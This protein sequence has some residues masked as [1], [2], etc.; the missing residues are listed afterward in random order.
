MRAM[1]GEVVSGERYI[2]KTAGNEERMIIDSASPL[3][4][5]DGNISGSV[6]VWTDITER[7]KLMIE[8]ERERDKL[9]T[10]IESISDEV[11][12]CDVEG[13]LVLAN[14]AVAQNLG[15]ERVEDLFGQVR[16]VPSKIEVYDAQ[17]QPLSENEAPLLRSLRGETLI[18]LEEF[19]RNVKTGELRF[20]RDFGS[21][22]RCTGYY[23]TQ[24]GP[25]C[26]T[27]RPR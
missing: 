7:E 16:E 3:Y 24:A 21:G 25:G 13:N 6:V 17:G 23:R 22:S 4:T 11:W 10:L 27:A 12:F 19:V 8:V 26:P 20:G 1:K 14:K 5:P 2:L 9:R 15:L 18:G